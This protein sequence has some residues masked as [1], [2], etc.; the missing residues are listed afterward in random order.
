M[1]QQGL[2]TNL[3]FLRLNF[4]IGLPPN[5]VCVLRNDF[6]YNMLLSK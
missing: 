6:V 1:H 2:K 3:D 4:L 5:P